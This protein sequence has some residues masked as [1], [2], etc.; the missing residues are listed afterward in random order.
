MS[1][2]EWLV[3]AHEGPSAT[4]NRCF[5][6]AVAAGLPGGM[7]FPELAL[8]SR[9]LGWEPMTL[10]VAEAELS[11]G[12]KPRVVRFISDMGFGLDSKVAAI[13]QSKALYCLESPLQSKRFHASLPKI[14]ASFD[15]AFLFDGLLKHSRAKVNH[16]I[17]FPVAHTRPGH[18]VD[19]SSRKKLIAVCS[20]KSPFAFRVGGQGSIVRRFAK[21]CIYLYLKLSHPILSAPDYYSV[22]KRLVAQLARL[23]EIDLYGTGWEGELPVV[24]SGALKGPL[25][26]SSKLATMASYQ[27][28]I[29]FE[30]CGFRG[31]ITEKIYDCI[32][33]GVI[34]VYLGAPDISERIPAGCFIDYRQFGSAGLMLSFLQQMKAEQQEECLAAG[35]SFLAS[36][37]FLKTGAARVAAQM[38][39]VL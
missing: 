35:A 38:I 9:R 36:E 15:A 19:F 16:R 17:Y 21:D 13:A 39:R 1:N 22:R 23:R 12:A 14:S 4:A 27:F 6:A 33:A 28:C 10:D 20:N 7:M 18:S 32:V 26:Y 11:R 34:P 3:V 37:E 5:E 25:A 29:C 24:R 30:N 2:I 8:Q 31:Y